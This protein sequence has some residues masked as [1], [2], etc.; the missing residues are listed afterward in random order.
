MTLDDLRL[1][2]A[3][4]IDRH[5]LPTSLAVWLAFLVFVMLLGAIVH[6]ADAQTA[7]DPSANWPMNLTQSHSRALPGTVI[8]ITSPQKKMPT[9]CYWVQDGLTPEHPETST[10]V[11]P[12]MTLSRTLVM[13]EGRDLRHGIVCRYVDMP[14]GFMLVNIVRAETLATIQEPPKCMPAP[15]GTGTQAYTK[16]HDAGICAAWFCED[17]NSPTGYS[18]PGACSTW[19]EMKGWFS[20]QE[21]LSWG[22][23][24]AKERWQTNPKW[25]SL[26]D[27]ERTVLAELRT[28]N[29]PAQVTFVTAKNG[30][31]SSRPVYGR[32]DDG[33][34][35]TAA[36]VGQRVG[37]GVA[38]DCTQRTKETS[39][40]CSV[41]GKPNA[42]KAG[43]TLPE[44][45][46]ALCV[47]GTAAP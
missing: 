46:F 28:A 44:N 43:E 8:E 22:E 10:N 21:V 40:Y 30:I 6:R 33:S 20:L 36:T 27:V 41:A 12:A 24:G 7:P 17:L 5:Y 25:R 23:A 39:L 31:Y 35:T 14:G 19:S 9:S 2:L 32:N 38:C 18:S 13:P 3:F 45:S 37:I 16:I 26:L 1:R 42:A 29:A 11:A 47:R 15:L 4:W 34:R